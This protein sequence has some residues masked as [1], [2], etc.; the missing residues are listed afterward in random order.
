MENST[1][2]DLFNEFSE[3][4]GCH[5]GDFEGSDLADF[6]IAA[7]HFL[8]EIVGKEAATKGMA[9]LVR[10]VG[11]RCD[12]DED[13]EE[14]LNDRSLDVFSEW[15]V[16]TLF[17]GLN[18]YANYGIALTAGK[19]EVEREQALAN[20]IEQAASL[21][22]KVPLKQW[23]LK[24]D[25]AARTV[26]LAQ[27]RWALDHGHPI[28][29]AALATFAGVTERRVRNLMAGEER[30]F[31]TSNGKI[32]A[33][34]ALDWLS[35][36]K[37]FRPSIWRKQEHDYNFVDGGPSEYDD[38][39]LFVPVAKDG[40]IFSPKLEKEGKFTVGDSKT[41]QSFGSFRDALTALQKMRRAT[42]QRPN[43]SG[44][45]SLVSAVSWE[46]KTISDLEQVR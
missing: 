4:Y 15:P 41:G 7:G 42:W 16:G 31:R 44:A 22:A 40:S 12:V 19:T 45:W 46:R 32:F 25:D 24:G 10:G 5:Q 9:E 17:F 36:K 18:A 21:M 34:D 43:N 35:N 20:R 38:E 26:M 8:S 23:D 27:G 2:Q 28:E 39:V 14:T 30:I 29:P 6:V 37:E 3:K 1:F 33:A 13:W 11:F